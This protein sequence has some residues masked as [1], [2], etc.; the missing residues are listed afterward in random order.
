MDKKTFDVLNKLKEN[1]A[2]TVCK[3]C[4]F[5]NTFHVCFLTETPDTW[6]LRLFENCSNCAEYYNGRCLHYGDDAAAS[7][8]CS[9]F[10]FKK[11]DD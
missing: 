8:S 1:C 10:Y 5:N 11:E 4:E 7:D 9:F 2:K 6:D 3:Y